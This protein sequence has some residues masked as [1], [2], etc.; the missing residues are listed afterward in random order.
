MRFTTLSRA[1]RVTGGLSPGRTG[2][3]DPSLTASDQ[4]SLATLTN[5]H[6]RD[7]DAEGP[8]ICHG[9]AGVLQATARADTSITGQ[10][11]RQLSEAFDP[12]YTFAFRHHSNG[13]Q[14]DRPGLLTGAC[15]IALVLADYGALA[16]AEVPTSWDAVLLLT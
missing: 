4:A 15:G 8:T 5:R 13:T 6:P 2:I 12:R 14:S 16:S 9:Y 7:W 10:A 1:R 11:A 3:N